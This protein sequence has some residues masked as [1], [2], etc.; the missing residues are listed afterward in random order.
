MTDG[1][2]AKEFNYE[3]RADK[4]YAQ[5]LIQISQPAKELKEVSKIVEDLG[6]H[7]VETKPLSSDW[8]IIKLDVRDMRNVALKLT[9]FGFSIKGINARTSKS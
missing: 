6:I 7:I 3:I 2:R 4:N 5:I 1:V 9:E 8:V